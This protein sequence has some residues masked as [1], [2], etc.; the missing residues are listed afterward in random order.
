MP[1]LR[2]LEAIVFRTLLACIAVFAA[3][4]SHA[5]VLEIEG[6]V[7][8]IDT[9]SR[10]VAITRK[11]A[12]GVKVVKL[13]VAKKAGDLS[14]IKEGDTLTVSY[15]SDLEIATKLAR[16][17]VE[18]IREMID[19]SP[20]MTAA[21]H[22]NGKQVASGTGLIR[23]WNLE[24]SNSQAVEL[25]HAPVKQLPHIF[26]TWVTFSPSGTLL[27]SACNDGSVRLWDI[28]TPTPKEWDV[29]TKNTGVVTPICFSPD[30]KLL[31]T[32]ERASGITRL[33]DVS[34]TKAKPAG[35]L[36]PVDGDVWSI[37]FSP[38]GK[39]LVAGMW[40]SDAEPK[41]GE[42]VAWDLTKAP[43]SRRV[44]VPKTGLPRGI[45]F[46]PDGKSVVFGDKGLVRHVSVPDGT[47][48]GV[49][50]CYPSDME[51]VALAV[52][53]NGQYVATGGSSNEVKVTEIK[54]G[55]ELD[56]L[57]NEYNRVRGLEFSPDGKKLLIGSGDSKL[58]LWEPAL[59]NK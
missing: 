43:A 24:D 20:V 28:S 31:A 32:A 7:K 4:L 44:I 15:D 8:A 29:I 5:E 39:T 30:G 12:N 2:R 35:V 53:P 9:D 1:P 26:I 13:D 46:L 45:Q 40:F 6:T 22:P 19:K 33:F 34:G 17:G 3:S 11:T 27:A 23:L 14:G 57:S 41:Y 38:D 55:K 18:A 58:R 37:A 36:A 21:F 42:V 10:T 52:S 49:L 54:T 16:A 25:K 48:L 56:I 51:I 50:D 59:S 47:D